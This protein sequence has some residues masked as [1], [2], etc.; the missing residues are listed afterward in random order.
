MGHQSNSTEKAYIFIIIVILS[1]RIWKIVAFETRS[2]N[3]TVR[4][5]YCYM[6]WNLP[7]PVERFKA[8]RMCRIILR[9][10]YFEPYVSHGH[11]FFYW[12]K[13][14]FFSNFDFCLSNSFFSVL[15]VFLIFISHDPKCSIALIHNSGPP[16]VT[17]LVLRPAYAPVRALGEGEGNLKES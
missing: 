2:L 9:L 7:L 8:V 10:N 16:L 6:I 13:T 5:A 12:L 15:K 3:F 11:K 14:G 4:E 1:L 17:F